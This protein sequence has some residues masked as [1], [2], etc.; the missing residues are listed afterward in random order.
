MV[1]NFQR[2]RTELA[3]VLFAL[4]ESGWLES[5][6]RK[7][8]ECNTAPLWRVLVNTQVA[9]G[10]K[11]EAAKSCIRMAQFAESNNM[12]ALAATSRAE[13]VTLD[14]NVKLDGTEADF[15]SQTFMTK[16]ELRLATRDEII[17]SFLRD[18]LNQH[19]YEHLVDFLEDEGSIVNA[20]RVIVAHTLTKHVPAQFQTNTA[21]PLRR[22]VTLVSH[23]QSKCVPQLQILATEA[24]NLRKERGLQPL[25]PPDLQSLLQ[26]PMREEEYRSFTVNIL[27]TIAKKIAPPPIIQT[28][29]IAAGN[30]SENQNF[31][32]GF[33]SSSASPPSSP[34]VTRS[35]DISSPSNSPSG[36]PSITA[37][38]LSRQ[39]NMPA[40]RSSW[41][42]RP[43]TGKDR[44]KRFT[45]GIKTLSSASLGSSNGFGSRMN[46]LSADSRSQTSSDLL[47]SNSSS[48]SFQAIGGSS[49]WG[50]GASN[51]TISTTENP[52]FSQPLDLPSRLHTPSVLTPFDANAFQQQYGTPPPFVP[53]GSSSSVG[54]DRPFVPGASAGGNIQYQNA[55]Q[56]QHQ[57][58]HANVTPLEPLKKD[59]LAADDS[60]FSSTVFRTL[61][62]QLGGPAPSSTQAQANNA[63]EDLPP[64]PMDEGEAQNNQNNQNDLQNQTNQ[65][66]YA[67]FSTPN[68]TVVTI[69]K[70]SN[71]TA[72]V[73]PTPDSLD[74]PLAE[75]LALTQDLNAQIAGLPVA[76]SNIE[77][78][79]AH[80]EEDMPPP[81]PADEGAPLQQNVSNP[82]N[83]WTLP[84]SQPLAWNP[85]GAITMPS[86]NSNT[87]ATS[88]SG[89]PPSQPLTNIFASSDPN[90]RPPATTA[91]SSGNLVVS[92][93]PH[94][95]SPS[96]LTGMTLSGLVVPS[97]GGISSAPHQASASPTQFNPALGSTASPL[98]L[99]TNQN[100]SAFANAPNTAA[101]AST[102]PQPTAWSGL[103]PAAQ[104]SNPALHMPNATNPTYANPAFGTTSNPAIAQTN[105]SSVSQN[106]ALY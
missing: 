83:A 5:M 87:F 28:S 42:I 59:F 60:P 101:P 29:S 26:Q 16:E 63:E 79:K 85:S 90:L 43:A 34:G 99:G 86:T 102:S 33:A 97:N 38:P 52:I 100:N 78:T 11:T 62:D 35:G 40:Q 19:N 89:L 24:N 14:P 18:P 91:V 106:P 69:D 48:G 77:S 27:E 65:T 71:Q 92:V 56:A 57:S 64:P 39:T 13:A 80:V 9:F 49:P 3:K 88:S 84:P 21:L 104:L 6:L 55:Q 12:A 37:S 44:N 46:Q 22:L 105:N 25:S 66:S 94:T 70:P 68:V 54:I 72:A 58:Q 50:N 103:L 32:P 47:S 17:G 4:G 8:R 61:P 1:E 82:N 30:N 15:Q 36:T 96:P 98:L 41:G 2:I 95:R 81:P 31:S 74:D 75:I 93:A 76:P 23:L 67:S 10:W 73:G 45:M 7:N 53:G 20:V 51:R